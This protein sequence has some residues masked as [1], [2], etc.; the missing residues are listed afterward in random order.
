MDLDW[1]HGQEASL[2]ADLDWH[3]RQEASLIADLDWHH[4]QEAS[5]TAEGKT[6]SKSLGYGLSFDLRVAAVHSE[7]SSLPESHKK[8]KSIV[9]YF[10]RKFLELS[11]FVLSLCRSQE[12][13][14]T[15]KSVLKERVIGSVRSTRVPKSSWYTWTV[16]QF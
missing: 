4:R 6:V 9:S 10:N 12:P 16:D 14:L 5:L 15:S 11:F 7:A 8:N 3:H 2:T 13:P 1:L